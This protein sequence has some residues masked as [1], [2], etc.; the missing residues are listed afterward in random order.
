MSIIRQKRLIVVRILCRIWSRSLGSVGLE[1]QG[2]VI[3]VIPVCA[4]ANGG[5]RRGNT[6]TKP[7]LSN[8]GRFRP[9]LHGNKPVNGVWREVINSRF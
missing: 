1:L 3:I 8:C 9:F 6:I 7:A 4:N 5:V 2:E